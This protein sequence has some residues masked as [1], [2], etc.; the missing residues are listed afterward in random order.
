MQQCATV[1]I[2]E[3]LVR[4]LPFSRFSI[5]SF[6]V[7][8]E[9]IFCHSCQG[10]H[11][12]FYGALALIARAHFCTARMDQIWD[13][14]DLRTHHDSRELELSHR[15]RECM[16][17]VDADHR[18]GSPRDERDDTGRWILVSITHHTHDHARSTRCYAR[19]LPRILDR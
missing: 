5:L 3:Y 13:R 19:E 17:R 6:H 2:S 7:Y 14:V 4:F 9:A 15:I 18:N 10:D 8:I 11:Y 1:F 16:Y 12:I